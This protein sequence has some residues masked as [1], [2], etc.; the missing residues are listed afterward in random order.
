LDDLELLKLFDFQWMPAVNRCGRVRIA[1]HK[2]DF[3]SFLVG[4]S[5]E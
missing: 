2:F 1:I 5:A 4:I 3:E